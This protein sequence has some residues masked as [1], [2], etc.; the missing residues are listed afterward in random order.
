MFPIAEYTFGQGLLTV[1]AIFV[2][3]G[4]DPGPGHDPEATSSDDHDG[5]GDG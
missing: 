1:L 4:L 2:L 3:H 5:I